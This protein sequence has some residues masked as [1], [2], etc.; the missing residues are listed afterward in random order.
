MSVIDDDNTKKR[1]KERETQLK[2]R[3]NNA[4]ACEQKQQIS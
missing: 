2:N 4:N 3:I 1:E